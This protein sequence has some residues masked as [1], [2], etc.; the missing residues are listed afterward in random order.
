MPQAVVREVPR[1][2]QTDWDKLFW[3]R[4]AQTIR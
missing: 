1:E 4:L 2:V 3:L